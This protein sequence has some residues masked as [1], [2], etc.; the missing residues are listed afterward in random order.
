M[1]SKQFFVIFSLTDYPS[2]TR[3]QLA[4]A[5]FIYRQNDIVCPQCGVSIPL[6]HI[7]ED[8]EYAS[9]YFRQLHRKKVSAL[10]KRCSFLLCELGTNIDDLHIALTSKQQPLW[11]DAEVP[12]HIP[13]AKRLQS[14]E[15]W[16]DL[17]KQIV[18]AEKTYVTPE[19]MAKYGFFF[20]GLISV[21]FN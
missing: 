4:L 12:E 6:D 14:F 1:K 18:T 15:L 5:G 2:I 9:N 7:D 3:R 16:P 13:Y 21:V 17:Q 19:T 8:L 10:G 11:E 20:S